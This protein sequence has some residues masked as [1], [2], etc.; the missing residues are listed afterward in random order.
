MLNKDRIQMI[1]YLSRL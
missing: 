1:R